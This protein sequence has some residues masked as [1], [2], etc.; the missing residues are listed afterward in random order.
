LDGVD[1]VTKIDFV[2]NMM[3]TGNRSPLAEFVEFHL[4]KDTEPADN[5]TMDGERKTEAQ[6]HG[7]AVGILNYEPNTVAGMMRTERNAT[8]ALL[9]AKGFSIRQIE[10]LTGV[11]RSVVGKC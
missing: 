7:E 2:L 6:L 10:R 4:I 3:T 1:D 8:I 9:R 5:I 11:S